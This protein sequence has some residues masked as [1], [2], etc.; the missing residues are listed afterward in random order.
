MKTSPSAVEPDSDEYY[1]S[2]ARYDVDT[3]PDVDGEPD[4]ESEVEPADLN[5]DDDE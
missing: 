2:I 5:E 3:E 4:A 1:E